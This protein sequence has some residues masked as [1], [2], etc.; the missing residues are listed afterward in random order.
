MTENGAPPELR[1]RIFEYLCSRP[2]RQAT[3]GRFVRS[4]RT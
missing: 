3:T 1:Q 2:D 4:S